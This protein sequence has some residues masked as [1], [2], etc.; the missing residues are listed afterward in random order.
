MWSSDRS[1][2][3]GNGWA[4]AASPR[5]VQRS[6]CFTD[7]ELISITISSTQVRSLVIRS[8]TRVTTQN[9]AKETL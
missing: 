6:Q 9:Y 3:V 7:K 8:F 1:G 2:L 4:N 5:A